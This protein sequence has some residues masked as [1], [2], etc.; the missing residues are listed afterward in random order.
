MGKR[1][2]ARE[3]KKRRQQWIRRKKEQIRNIKKR[4]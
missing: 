3:K 1:H 4:K 2:N